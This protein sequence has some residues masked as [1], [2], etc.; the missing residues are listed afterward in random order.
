[1]GVAAAALLVMV[2][3][4]CTPLFQDG[5]VLTATNED[6]YV[7]L[8]WTQAVPIDEGTTVE[9][10]RID[11]NGVEVSRTPGWASSCVL[12]GLDNDTAYEI[13]VSAYDSNAH[14]SADGN[15]VL[16]TSVTTASGV[17]AGTELFCDSAPPPPPPDPGE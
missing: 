7:V 13:T 16:T 2:A 1:M 11:V 15:S 12:K 4:G 6:P 8:N 10:Y 9:E 14:W 17:D 5:A 3:A